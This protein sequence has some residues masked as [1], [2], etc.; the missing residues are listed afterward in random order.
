MQFFIRPCGHKAIFLGLVKKA[1]S[2]LDLGT[3]LALNR[4]KTATVA[5]CLLRNSHFH[6]DSHE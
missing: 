3:L 5:Q 1:I 6:L 2:T 4:P